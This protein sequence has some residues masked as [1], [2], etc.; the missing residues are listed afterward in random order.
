[1]LFRRLHRS[2]FYWCACFHFLF[3]LLFSLIRIHRRVMEALLVPDDFYVEDKVK[4]QY[5]HEQPSAKS[6]SSKKIAEGFT[7]EYSQTVP[8][9]IVLNFNGQWVQKAYTANAMVDPDEDFRKKMADKTHHAEAEAVQRLG[10]ISSASPGRSP[11][12]ATPSSQSRR[13]PYTPVAFRD[14]P[15]V[16]TKLEMQEHRQLLAFARYHCEKQREKEIADATPQRRR[17]ASTATPAM[18]ALPSPIAP[19][20]NGSQQPRPLSL[21]GG[22]NV[23][24]EE[25]EELTIAPIEWS[26]MQHRSEAKRR[27]QARAEL[28][29]RDPASAK[30]IVPSDAYPSL[31]ELREVMST[32]SKLDAKLAKRTQST[33]RSSDLERSINKSDDAR[34]DR[35]SPTAMTSP[36][37]SVTFDLN[38]PSTTVQS[39]SELEGNTISQLSHAFSLSDVGGGGST[40]N[41][42]MVDPQ[43]RERNQRRA[44][45]RRMKLLSRS[46]SYVPVVALARRRNA[47]QIAR[48][49]LEPLSSGSVLGGIHAMETRFIERD[50]TETCDDFAR[51]DTIYQTI[52][53]EQR[54]LRRRVIGQNRRAHA[55]DDDGLSDRA[56]VAET[57]KLRSKLWSFCQGSQRN[58]QAPPP[59]TLSTSVGEKVNHITA[60]QALRHKRLGVDPNDVIAELAM[61]GPLEIGGES[62]AFH[63]VFRAPGYEDL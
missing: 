48:F 32:S 42:G 14:G 17:R 54:R 21:S 20:L 55:T 29:K 40:E 46:A 16:D 33:A 38:S 35:S 25:A 22:F 45:E 10:S 4:S 47:T 27:A 12:S 37:H 51:G 9:E 60:V 28:A 50:V 23:S 53:K 11:T 41:L 13:R 49:N 61:C 62:I 36:Q 19:S 43:V 31:A 26:V 44:K 15:P 8:G 3:S 34:G 2:S 58:F 63:E 1:M 39:Q 57:N 24:G 6:K 52:A 18:Q 5:L 56:L 30:V 59:V 7:A